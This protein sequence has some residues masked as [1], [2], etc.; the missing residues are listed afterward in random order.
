MRITHCGLFLALF[1]A[2]CGDDS[3]SKDN[4]GGTVDGAVD[5]PTVTECNDGVDNDGDGYT[6]WQYDLGCYG[7][8]DTTEAAGTRAEED[9]FTTFE[10]AGDSVAIYVASDGDDTRDGLT[11]ATAV[12]TLTRG[13]AL[14]RD[15]QH[16]FLLLRRGDTWR[17]QTLGRF[18]SGR[19]ASHP[20]VIASY[21]ESVEM[22]LVEIGDHFIDHDGQARN[23]LAIIGLHF[24]VYRRAVGDPQFDG[25]GE[26][27][28]RFVGSGTNLLLEGNHL[29]FGEIV[30]Q[31]CCA[32]NSHYANVEVRRNVIEKSYH[33]NTC[34][35]GNPNGDSTF[36]PSGIYS[37]HV[38]GMLVEGNVFDHNGWNPEVPSACATIYNHNVYL[39]ATND[40]VIRDNIFARASSIHIKLRSDET[41]AMDNTLIEGNYFVE[42]EIGVSVGGNSDQ[43]ARFSN[44]TIR[45]NVLSDIGRSRPT[46]RTLAWGV[47]VIDND[48][49]SITDNYFLDQRESGVSNSYALQIAG[50]TERA[51]TVERNLFYRIQSTSLRSVSVAGHTNIRIAE[52]TFADPDQDSCLVTH[53]GAFG[54]YTYANNRYFSSADASRWFCAPGG[55]TSIEN[56]RT[57]SGEANATALTSLTFSDPDRTVEKYAT[58]LGL[59]ETLEAFL[60]AARGQQRLHWRNDLTAGAVNTYL[61]AGFE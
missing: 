13:A 8:A 17:D 7:P 15:G 60:G 20:L 35:P 47:E 1:V 16:D 26:G 58:T 22:P 37:S 56:W 39:A 31:S 38:E 25:A 50:G 52:N 14:V 23:H 53:S 6:D 49:V 19:D 54:Q 9:G 30:V 12:R 24:V 43:P 32:D 41:G 27:V 2:G 46:T 28:F 10:I 18:K 21:G 61:R 48:T 45:N 51:V 44:T 4:D 29:Q 55:R 59:A 33:R 11:P 42:G 3:S 36:R 34:L 57:T 5:A 40:L